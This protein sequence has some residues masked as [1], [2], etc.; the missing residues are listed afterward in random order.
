MINYKIYFHDPVAL[1]GVYLLYT[2]IDG[3]WVQTILPLF[4]SGSPGAHRNNHRKNENEKSVTTD[5]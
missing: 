2:F 5:K 4:V 1:K 3:I